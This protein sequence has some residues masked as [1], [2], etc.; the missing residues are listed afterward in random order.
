M[1]SPEQHLLS[2]LRA[3][4]MIRFVLNTGAQGKLDFS[5]E[6]APAAEDNGMMAERLALALRAL[7]DVGFDFNV[8][9]ESTSLPSVRHGSRK[10]PLQSMVKIR[11][12]PL[13]LSGL[14]EG[15]L[16]FSSEHPTPAH[17]VTLPSF[18]AFEEI[19]LFRSL[20]NVL[21]EVPE[22]M[23][24]EIEFTRFDLLGTCVKPL[25]RVLT[26]HS[27]SGVVPEDRPSRQRAFLSLWLLHR[28]GWRVKARAWTGPQVPSAA[29][30]IIGRDIFSCDCDVVSSED[31][32]QGEEDIDLSACYPRGW[33][34]LSILPPPEVFT[35][36]TASRL[37]NPSLPDLPK[38]GFQI[39]TADGEKVRLPQESRDR[40]TFICGA[41]GTG[42]STLLLRMI[43]E[44][45]KRGEGVILLD[46]H[47]DLY[48][49]VREAVPKNR[50]KDV[51]IIDPE[52][53][54]KPPGLNILDIPQSPFR[55]RHAAFV[56]GELLSFF[57]ELWDM[58]TAGGPMFELYFR[59]TVL[60]MCLIEKPAAELVE[61]DSAT[62]GNDK[63]ELGTE[64]GKPQSSLSPGDNEPK[65]K[66]VAEV[67]QLPLNLR[68]FSRV[69]VDKKFRETLLAQ[70]P[71]KSV[72]EFWK[73]VAGKAGG[74][75]SLA[76]IVPYIVSKINGMVQS[77]FV[78]DLLC[79]QRNE[80][81]LA[82]RMNR[83]EIILIN[84]NKGLLGGHESRLLGTIL[85]M[86]IFAAGLRR[87][88]LSEDQRR[89]VNVYVDEFQNFVSDNVSVM[90]SEARKFGLRL[91][92]ANQ[93]LA[94]LKANPGRQ[95]LLETVLGNV[96]NMILFRLG[97]PD[98]DRLKL[99]TEPFT[100][101]EMQDLPNFH[102]LVRL[103][104]A[105]GPIRPVVMKTMKA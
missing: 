80:F 20:A 11:P 10:R 30:E 47:G 18:H 29:L 68:H 96:G 40:H 94:Q 50:E 81:R 8:G 35:K 99:F 85:M 4:D 97:V 104:T 92:L 32:S 53:N 34:F 31:L 77:G 6:G 15:V 19:R 95:D 9:G 58:R 25:E 26:L 82:E 13:V 51:F 78:A 17:A 84:L 41:T 1:N 86:E 14:S 5:V 48:R 75:S 28:S 69:M 89:P 64:V 72:V 71:D 43:V 37:H 79:A 91:T 7:R 12:R 103:L 74:E 2:I 3:G 52:V 56:V 67:I 105:D 39:G 22:I 102:A 45:M 54:E 93:T 83:G 70:C 73:D 65:E 61:K 55:N 63:N 101:Q 21:L 49:A 24:F 66:P 23:R 36:L 100:R 38:A 62:N 42:K 76:N 60:L 88:V 16:G 46:P 27:L 90:L 44:D 87:S 57:A 33:R 98:A 59:N